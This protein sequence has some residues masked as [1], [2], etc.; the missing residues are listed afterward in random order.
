M[1][2]RID[3]QIDIAKQEIWL[4]NGNQRYKTGNWCNKNIW[5]SGNVG[6]IKFSKLCL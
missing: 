6:T 2:Y 4:N 5:S 3:G 1:C